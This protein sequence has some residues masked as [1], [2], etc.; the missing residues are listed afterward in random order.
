MIIT[1]TGQSMIRGDIRVDAPEAVPVIKRLV[2]GDAAFTN[3]EAAVCDAKKGQTTR[4]GRFASP[5]ES[6][7]ALK[8]FGFHLLSLANNHSFDL[9]VPGIINT[10]ETAER[11]KMAHAGTGRTLAEAEQDNL[12]GCCQTARSRSS[13]LPLA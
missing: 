5:P 8:Y 2:K 13:R 9:K 10:L 4:D 6:M 1:L 12:C 11:L 3:F 7:E